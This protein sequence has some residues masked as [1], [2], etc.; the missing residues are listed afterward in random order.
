MASFVPQGC[1]PQRIDEQ[2][3][4][5]P[6]PPNYEG[7]CRTTGATSA[8]ALRTDGG[9]R[10]STSCRAASDQGGKPRYMIDSRRVL[11]SFDC[12]RAPCFLTSH[13][14]SWQRT[15]AATQ[16]ERLA[17]VRHNSNAPAT[18]SKDDLERQ[19]LFICARLGLRN[20]RDVSLLN[21]VCYST[22]NLPKDHAVCVAAAEA[23]KANA[24]GRVR[25][26]GNVFGNLQDATGQTAIREF[27]DAHP[28]KDKKLAATVRCCQCKKPEEE[29]TSYFIFDSAQRAT[30]LR[31][32][33]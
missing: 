25:F 33:L 15:I 4:D 22:V 20:A 5:V 21:S 31:R 18:G 29:H 8:E 1:V 14:E 30:R 12:D 28:P 16:A 24:R 6:T 3:V 32:A 19:L 26:C 17:K 23:R 11:C 13:M 10:R 2:L 27:L 7:Y 9:L